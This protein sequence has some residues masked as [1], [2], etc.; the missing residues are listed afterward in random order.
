MDDQRFR[1]AF[2][3]IVDESPRPPRWDELVA[4]RGRS[5]R[6]FARRPGVAFFAGAVF[7]LAAVGVTAIVG[8][9]APPPAFGTTTT[10]TST[11]A[12]TVAPTTSEVVIEQMACG[13]AAAPYSANIPEGSELDQSALDALAALE[14]VG[15]GQFFTDTYEFRL[16]SQDDRELVL[17]GYPRDPEVTGYAYAHFELSEGAWAPTGFGGCSW[18]PEVE[19]YGVAAWRLAGDI[20]PDDTVLTI[21]ATEREC[22]GGQ[23]P[24]GRDVVDAVIGD[25]SSITVFVLV[26]PVQGDATCPSNPEFEYVV[27]LDETVGNRT[28]LD[29]S[30]SPPAVRYQPPASIDCPDRQVTGGTEEYLDII[31]LCDSGALD[32]FRV[33][34]RPLGDDPEISIAR[35]LR[36]LL[37]G[38]TADEAADGYVSF[39]DAESGDALES[40]NVKGTHAAVDFNDHI[41]INNASTSTGSVLLQVELLYN[42]LQTDQL[43]TVEFR[44]NGSCEAW[45]TFLQGSGC[46]VYTRDDLLAFLDQL[47]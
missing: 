18:Q 35:V 16:W 34:S 23:A 4:G 41:L 40:V 43:E 17:L 5:W 7:V 25:E 8:G 36:E 29:G 3:S 37:T 31:L 14:L 27:T 32:D 20:K 2:Q 30:E 46:R 39:F 6:D 19:G 45:S 10:T 33:V 42:I 15:E 24:L 28:L 22:A 9:D 11:T 38:P 13:A 47:N 21:L 1:R 26:E 12:T 44:V